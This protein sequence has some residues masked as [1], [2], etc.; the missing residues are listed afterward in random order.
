[1]LTQ[2]LMWAAGRN[3]STQTSHRIDGEKNTYPNIQ[4]KRIKT[5][6]SN[7]KKAAEAGFIQFNQTNQYVL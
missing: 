4:L 3:L 7:Q 1:M 2:M 5:P 6:N